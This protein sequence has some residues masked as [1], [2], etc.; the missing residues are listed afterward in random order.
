MADVGRQLAGVSVVSQ[1][2]FVQR[3]EDPLATML[4][5]MAEIG[6]PAELIDELVLHVERVARGHAVQDVSERDKAMR[7]VRRQAADGAV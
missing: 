2:A 1:Q 7:D 6:A 4:P 3:L 5:D